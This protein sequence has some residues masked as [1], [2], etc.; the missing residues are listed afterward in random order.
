MTVKQAAKVLGKDR[1]D[2]IRRVAVEDGVPEEANARLKF[3]ALLH[4]A[5]MSH[6]LD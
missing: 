1:A 4:L 3:A 6:G 5:Y 2:E